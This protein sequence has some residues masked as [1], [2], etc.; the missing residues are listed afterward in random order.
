MQ[1]ELLLQ[2]VAQQVVVVDDDDLL[3][4]AHGHLFLPK[5]LKSLAPLPGDVRLLPA[6]FKI[7]PQH[8]PP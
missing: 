1:R 5:C 6:L 3:R 2:G 7:N 8:T 4:G